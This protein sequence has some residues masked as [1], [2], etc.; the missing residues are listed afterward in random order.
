MK[1]IEVKVYDATTDELIGEFDS[2]AIASDEYGVS[3][4]TIRR[5]NKG[6]P[7]SGNIYFRYGETNRKYTNKAKSVIWYDAKT[8]VIL[9]R[10]NS[11][12]EAHQETGIPLST[13]RGNCRGVT[14]TVCKKKYYFRSPE[15]EFKPIHPEPYIQKGRSKDWLK[16]AVDVYSVESDNVIGSFGSITEA[17]KYIGCNPSTVSTNIGN[18][19]KYKHQGTIYKKYYCKYHNE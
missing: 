9:G 15:I 14:K 3:Q 18:R 11:A 5:S 12:L 4:E 16:K 2:V 17:A 10:F 8:G 1:G 7:I 19:L 13:I 6:I